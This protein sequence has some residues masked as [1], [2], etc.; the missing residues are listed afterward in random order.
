MNVATVEQQ[1]EKKFFTLVEANQRLPLVRAIVDDIVRLF[2]DVQ[3]RRQRLADLLQRDTIRPKRPSTLYTEEL[4]QMDAE[5]RAD[6]ERLNG[7]AHELAEL[8]VEL[9]DPNIG[10]CDFPTLVEGRE[11][12][13]C[14]KL[15]E[16]EVG[17]WHDLHAGFQGRQSVADL[18][19]QS[20]FATSRK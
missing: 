9:K 11:A 10:L 16:P 6:I 20:R 4:E 3:E 1:H 17:F 15:D 14:W 7:F 13:L 19:P 5:I 2:T 12:C 8:G 18:R